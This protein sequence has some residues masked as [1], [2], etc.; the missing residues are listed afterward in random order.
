MM[1][2]DAF[3]DWE[4]RLL[5]LIQDAVHAACETADPHETA[6]GLLRARALINAWHADYQRQIAG[7]PGPTGRIGGPG[8]AGYPLA[9]GPTAPKGGTPPWRG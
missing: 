9:P 1:A 7:T 4:V 8:G 3:S 5:A 2:D 6:Q